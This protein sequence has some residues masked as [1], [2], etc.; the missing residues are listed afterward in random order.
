M[1]EPLGQTRRDYANRLC[2]I[3]SAGAAEAPRANCGS[4]CLRELPVGIAGGEQIAVDLAVEDA[5][6][7]D[8]RRC[9]QLPIGGFA[10]S[11][12]VPRRSP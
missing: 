6:G 12:A 2:R 1:R 9:Y 4:V 11:R 7:R 5:I 3:R 8:T 10:P